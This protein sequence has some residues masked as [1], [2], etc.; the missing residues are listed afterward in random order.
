MISAHLA[1]FRVAAASA[2]LQDV[3][4]VVGVQE[5]ERVSTTVTSHVRLRLTFLLLLL[6]L[7]LLTI[8][9]IIVIIITIII[10]TINAWHAS[11]TQIGRVPQTSLIKPD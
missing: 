3:T 7:L 10:I 9:I 11:G 2:A 5:L 6:L 8:I 1:L 4:D